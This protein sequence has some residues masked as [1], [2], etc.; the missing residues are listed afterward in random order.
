MPVYRARLLT[1]IDADLVRFL[2]DALIEVDGT[3]RIA[4]VRPP[5][6]TPV[7]EDLRPGVLV[8]GFVD[9][10]V[11]FPQTRI[12]G[13]ASGPLLQ[14]LDRSTFPEESRF[15]DRHHAERIA[16]VFCAN[17][18]ASG[19]TFAFV[20]GSVHAEA[21]QILFAALDRWGLR[22]IAGPV[23]MN[24]DCPPDLIVHPT[25]A[26]AAVEAL[27]DRW[28]GHDGRLQVAVIP[29]FALS[30]TPQMLLGAGDLARRRRL[31]TS[32]HLAETLDE[33]A[34]AVK[35][36]GAP[37]YL[38]V[39]EQAG[40]VHDRS[41]FAHCIHL[42]DS[43]WDR[44]AAAKAVVAHCPDSNAFLGSGHMPVME[45]VRRGI[46]IAIGSD[47]AA[48]RSFRIPRILSSAWDNARAVG[49]EITPERLL[50]WGTR[51]GALAL[52]EPR[53]GLI[54]HGYEADMAL[55]EL[56]E[57]VSTGDEALGWLLF[58]HDAPRPRRTWVRGRVVW[59]RR[60]GDYPWRGVR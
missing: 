37:D 15:A 4:D 1:P 45:P 9:A 54:E 39:Y 32:T 16:E 27:A 11:H 47:V 7:D 3:G 36:S 40:L 29:R 57:W 59:T 28:N 60:S 38:A 56:P 12:V 53:V 43:E 58:D 35:R 44:L 20:Y 24:D 14:W 51:G 55:F 22:A 2:D 13:A 17:L 46:P 18:A 31:W 50:W 33:C 21:T 42:S 25:E 23:L 49:A 8:P 52:G 41:V 6:G 10:H 19:T 5:D 48:G 34:I 26:L 30:C